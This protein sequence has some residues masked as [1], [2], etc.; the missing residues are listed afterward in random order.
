MFTNYELTN[1]A[2]NAMGIPVNKL[3]G[4]VEVPSQKIYKI[5]DKYYKLIAIAPYKEISNFLNE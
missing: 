3:L 5:Y 2:V 1:F 4:F